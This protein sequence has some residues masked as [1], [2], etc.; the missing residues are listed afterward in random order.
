VSALWAL[1]AIALALV[2]QSGLTLLVPVHAALF[3]PLL[4]ITVY[5][6]LRRGETYGMLTGAA[7]GWAQEIVFGGR[8]LGVQGLARLIVGFL[9][10]QAGRRF[11]LTGALSQFVVVLVAALA[12]IWLAA[13][14]AAMFEIQRQALSWTVLVARVVLNAACGAMAFGLADWIEAR[15]SRETI[16]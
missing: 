11:L 10:G 1:V 9:V 2:L 13:G 16:A 15:V 8:I 4:L 7:T 14:L 6:S 3:D 5:V 12:D